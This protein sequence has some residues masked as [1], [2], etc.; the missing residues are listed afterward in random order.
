MLAGES[1]GLPAGLSLQQELVYCYIIGKNMV[2]IFP[3]FGFKSESF[4]PPVMLQGHGRDCRTEF[5]FHTLMLTNK[6]ECV[7]GDGL[8]ADSGFALL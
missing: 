6:S 4:F 5:R 7:I 3:M 1:R 8:P 2:I